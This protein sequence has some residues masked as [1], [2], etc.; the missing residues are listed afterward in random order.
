MEPTDK[1][2]FPLKEAYAFAEQHGLGSE[3]ETI[4][5]MEIEWD[6]SYNSTVR[7]GKLI[8]LFKSKQLLDEF[9][10]VI[11]KNGLTRGGEREL[12]A[13]PRIADEYE[14]FLRGGT[15]PGPAEELEEDAQESDRFAIEAHLRDFLAKNLHRIEPGLHVFEADGRCGVEYSVDDG[16]IDILAVDAQNKFVVI[17]LKLSRGRNRTIGQLL[18]Y[19]GW[20]DEHLKNGPCRGMIIANEL[21][22]DLITAVKRVPGVMLAKYKMTFAVERVL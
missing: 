17:E 2:R 16:R 15:I 18:Y 3:A 14:A 7:R 22:D 19:M 9:I 12:R 8:Q 10:R 4:R 5:Q 13:C 21:G 20:V 1:Y 6:R 11:W